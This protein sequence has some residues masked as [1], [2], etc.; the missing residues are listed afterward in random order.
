MSEFKFEHICDL[1]NGKIAISKMTGKDQLYF[2]ITK[3]FRTDDGAWAPTK[4]GVSVPAENCVALYHALGQFIKDNGITDS[5]KSDD[6]DANPLSVD[7]PLSSDLSDL[8]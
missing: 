8:S 4:Q 6:S 7:S 1:A 2:R 5:A 3:Q